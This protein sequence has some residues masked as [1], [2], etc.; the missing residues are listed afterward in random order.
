V[1]KKSLKTKKISTPAHPPGRVLD[2]APN[3]R[4]LCG[5]DWAGLRVMGRNTDERGGFSVAILLATKDGARFLRD[6]LDSFASQTH[7]NWRLYASDDWSS[8]K[9]TEILEEFKRRTSSWVEVRRGPNKGPAENFLSLARDPEIEADFFA[10]SD[11]D[12]IWL[13]DKLERAVASLAGLDSVVPAFYC[14]RTLL[15]D[16]NNERVL[17]TSQLFDR[18]PAFGNA[19]VQS[20][21]GGNTTVFNRAAKRLLEQARVNVVIHDWWTYQ[22]VTGAGGVAVYDEKPSL[23]YRQHGANVIGSNKG[24]RAQYRRLLMMIE[25]RFGGWN[26]INIMALLSLKGLLTAESAKQLMLFDGA[27][28]GHLA[29]RVAS[30]WRSGI[31]R[32][33]LQGNIALYVAA[34][35]SKL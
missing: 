35:L 18:K 7:R 10:F 6:Q 26:E 8:D 3:M 28:H 15:V 12:D 11:Q 34:V 14:S 29:R 13:N 22:L 9:T 4:Q 16:E 5:D 32:Q 33:T 30:V 17:G 1:T 2:S 20:L 24:W 23:R 31:Y 27:R 25:G 19:L 21:G